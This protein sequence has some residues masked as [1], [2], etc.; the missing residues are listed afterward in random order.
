[1]DAFDPIRETAAR[2]HTELVTSGAD[3]SRSWSMVEAAIRQL[4]L[5]LVWLPAGDPA[6]K[7]A[8]A[9]FDEQSGTICCTDRGDAGEAR[10]AHRPRDRTCMRSRDIVPLH[11]S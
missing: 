6:L 7:G 4:D 3:P 1:M 8:F 11:G 9:L 5:E 2:L 10:G